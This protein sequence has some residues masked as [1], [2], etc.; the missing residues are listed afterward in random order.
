MVKDVCACFFFYL[1]F[2]IFSGFNTKTGVLGCLDLLLP[3]SVGMGNLSERNTTDLQLY[4]LSSGFIYFLYIN[5]YF[6]LQY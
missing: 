1:L 5:Y 6:N 4:S 2:F 3:T